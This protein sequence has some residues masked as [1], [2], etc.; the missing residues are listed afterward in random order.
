MIKSKFI[1]DIVNLILDGEDI[2]ES[3]HQKNYLAEKDFEYTGVGLFVYFSHL[4]GINKFK[5]INEKLIIDGLTIEANELGSGGTVTMFFR[6]GLVDYIEIWSRNGKFPS[7][8]LKNYT[9]TQE[10]IG[11]SGKKII[12]D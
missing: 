6:E 9:L 5:T 8:E 12:V 10:W 4:E 1:L 7:Q 11:S 3:R 2:G